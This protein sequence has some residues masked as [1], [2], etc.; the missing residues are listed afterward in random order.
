MDP[1]LYTEYLTYASRHKA[2]TGHVV[3]FRKEKNE[4]A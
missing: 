1:A 4:A 2:E 3:Y